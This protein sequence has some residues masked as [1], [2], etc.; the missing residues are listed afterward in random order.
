MIF[1]SFHV[2]PDTPLPLEPTG[3]EPIGPGAF[4][5]LEA[6]LPSGPLLNDVIDELQMLGPCTML[7][8]GNAH[9]IPQSELMNEII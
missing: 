5:P 3:D 1:R 6:L 4:G 2:I 8:H 9:K 7:I